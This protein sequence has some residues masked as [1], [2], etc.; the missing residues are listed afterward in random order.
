MVAVTLVVILL[1]A[2][3]VG[4][5]LVYSRRT[6]TALEREAAVDQQARHAVAEEEE[7]S[8]SAAEQR[9]TARRDTAPGPAEREIV[10]ERAATDD[11]A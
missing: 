6:P 7:L 5:L 8:V 3:A 4:G 10:R 2:V 1:L 9:A 11:A